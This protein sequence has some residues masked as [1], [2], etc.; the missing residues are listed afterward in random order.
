MLRTAGLMVIGNVAIYAI[1]VT[2][3]CSRL[4]HLGHGTESGH[5]A[6]SPR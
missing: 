3:L 1:G 2:Y 5:G 6:F 4:R